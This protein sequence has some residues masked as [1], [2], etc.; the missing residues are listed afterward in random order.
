V[1]NLSGLVRCL[2]LEFRQL[3]T[4]TDRCGSRPL[5]RGLAGLWVYVT[6]AG[7]DRKVLEVIFL[8]AKE[9]KRTRYLLRL[10]SA[11]RVRFLAG[12]V[13]IATL[14]KQTMVAPC[15]GVFVS[16]VTSLGRFLL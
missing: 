6:E 12:P 10:K 1:S 11:D 9:G 16:T 5:G 14:Q 8:G 2:L 3:Y 13:L 7:D 15:P 4:L